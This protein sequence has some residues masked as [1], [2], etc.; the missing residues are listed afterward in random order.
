MTSMQIYKAKVAEF[1]KSIIPASSVLI[2]THDFPDPD[3]LASAFGLQL[4][5][6]EWGVST[7]QIAFGGFIGRAENRAMI[8][9]LN[10]Q[11]IPL[12]LIEVEDYERIIVVDTMPGEGNISLDLIQ[13]ID[14]VIDHH[15]HPAIE[16][17]YSFS[18]IRKDIGATSTIITQYLLAEKCTIPPIVATALFYGIKTDTNQLSR[19]ISPDDIKSYQHLFPLIDHGLLAN[20]ESPDRDIEYFKVMYRAVE[21]MTFYGENIGYTHLGIVPTPDYV[22]E[23][24]DLFHSLENLE[25]MI[26]SAIF[27][28][29]IYFSIRSRHQPSA[30]TY[31]RK[32]ARKLR[33]FGGG[34]PTLAAGRIPLEENGLEHDSLTH[35]LDNF[36]NTLAYIFKIKRNRI[37]PLLK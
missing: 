11:S 6:G 37:R 36:V 21:A 30:G 29:Q 10:I 20:I 16:A 18:D 8:R 4:L 5:L 13:R 27:K 14:V 34:H 25:W 28:K 3:C 31:A 12:M 22:A 23:I 17:D 32:I 19:N 9:F 15:P 33:G 2:V 26:C 24:A 7:V 1:K 35:A